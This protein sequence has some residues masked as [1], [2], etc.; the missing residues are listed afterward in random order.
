MIGVVL[1]A[2]IVLVVLPAAFFATWGVMAWLLGW[3]LT[4]NA[5]RTHA[6]SDLIATNV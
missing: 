6:G 2:L 3:L 4:D 1:I 5:E